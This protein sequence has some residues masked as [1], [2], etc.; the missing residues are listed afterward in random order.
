VGNDGVD[1]VDY[2]GK[3]LK[4]FVKD[5]SV[6]KEVPKSLDGSHDGA[7]LINWGA[8]SSIE[9]G[10]PASLWGFKVW[11]RVI[12]SGDLTI[13]AAWYVGGNGG[14]ETKAHEA[15]HLAL[16]GKW[17]NLLAAEIN[18]LEAAYCDP[19]DSLAVGYAQAASDYY[20]TEDELENAKFDLGEYKKINV[21]PA[22]VRDMAA[23]VTGLEKK[24]PGIKSTYETSAKNFN[25][26]CVGK[27][28]SR[29]DL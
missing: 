23:K 11:R 27:G 17:W 4:A 13:D 16:H 19:C 14:G 1:G 8:V 15:T 21:T 22:R 26:K 10:F 20:Y 18:P 7:V 6:I 29:S 24:L 28:M 5:D 25:A 9:G 2:L 3:K 12:V